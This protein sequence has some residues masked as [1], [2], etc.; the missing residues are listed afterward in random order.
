MYQLLRGLKYI[1]SANVLH[2]D[3]KPSNI[4]LNA[5]GEL[6]ICDFGLA[7]VAS[8]AMTEYVGTRWYRAP[9]L[10]LNSSAYTSAIDV[11]SVGCIFFQMLTRTPLFPG[12]NRDHQLRLILEVIFFKLKPFCSNITFALCFC[13]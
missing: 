1:H 10:L 9:E 8:D 12:G 2:R 11:W 7:R 6:K 4:L 5:N 3:L 13:S